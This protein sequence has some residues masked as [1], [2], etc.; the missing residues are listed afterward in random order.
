MNNIL[1]KYNQLELELLTNKAID[2]LKLLSDQQYLDLITKYP[3]LFE[4]NNFNQ[5]HILRQII[6][7]AL[8]YIN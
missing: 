8:E 6:D 5:L 7:L 2:I 4:S 3:Y 1:D